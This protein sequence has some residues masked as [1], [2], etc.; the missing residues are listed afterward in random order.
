MC[1]EEEEERRME[2]EEGPRAAVGMEVRM[3]W[4]STDD[5]SGRSKNGESQNIQEGNIRQA[6]S[7]QVQSVPYAFA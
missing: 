6:R 4:K 1:V 7:N 3:V 5:N 2:L